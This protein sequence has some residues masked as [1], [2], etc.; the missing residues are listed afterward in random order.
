MSSFEPTSSTPRG[1]CRGSASSAS[2][3]SR[4]AR[5]QR[6]ALRRRRNEQTAIARSKVEGTRRVPDHWTTKSSR[7]RGPFERAASARRSRR[8]EQTA[9]RRPRGGDGSGRRRDAVLRELA[10]LD[11]RDAAPDRSDRRSRSRRRRAGAGRR[12]SVARAGSGRRPRG[13]PTSSS[14]RATSG[15]SPPSVPAF[16]SSA[17]ASRRISSPQR[18]ATGASRTRTRPTIGTRR[19]RGDSKSGPRVR[20]PTPG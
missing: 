20:L 18:S 6:P 1:S 10:H 12:R 9:R 8:R 2:T 3:A 15:C 11:P 14:P 7:L 16:C 19:E 17:T 13:V 4:F 5:A